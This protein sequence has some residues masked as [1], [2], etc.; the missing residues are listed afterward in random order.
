MSL[1]KQVAL[2]SLLPVVALGFV[3][4]R[5][6]QAQ[7]SLAISASR[8]SPRASRRRP[9]SS[10]SPRS[11]ASAQ[12]F[13]ISRPLPSGELAA[14]LGARVGGTPDGAAASSRNGRLAVVDAV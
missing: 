6:L 1:T 5:V 4:A 3:L 13:L 14:L 9:S 8:S 11:A 10:A 7:T 2:L 12:G